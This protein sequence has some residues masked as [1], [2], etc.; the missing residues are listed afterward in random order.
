[1]AT[2][3]VDVA[4]DAL[5]HLGKRRIT[6]LDDANEEARVM[7]QYFDRSVDSVLRGYPFHCA[8][9][10][11]Q[12]SRLAEAPTYGYQHRYQLPTSPYCLRVIAVKDADEASTWQRKGRTI[13]T[14]L[15]TCTIEYIG[16]TDV[17]ELDDLVNDAIAAYIAFRAAYT[18]TRSRSIQ[19]DMHALFRSLRKEA[20]AADGTEGSTRILRK[21][22]IRQARG[23]HS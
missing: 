14:D 9:H 18:L 17:S 4:N 12:L 5:T 21:S 7:K 16:R 15:P 2:S 22:S 8:R 1:M 3:K 19:N 10:L 6:A 23:R 20:I 13:H 11:Q